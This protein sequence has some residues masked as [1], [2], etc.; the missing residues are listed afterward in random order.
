MTDE[1]WKPISG[2]EGVY[3]VSNLGRVRSCDRIVVCNDGRKYK[4]KG[5]VLRQSY[6]A[7]KY[8]KVALCKNGKQKNF[9]VH[10]LVA[11]AFIPNPENKLTVNHKNGDKLDNRV[12]NLEW[13]TREEN[14]Q[15]AYDNGLK[16]SIKGS[17]NSNSKLSDDDV[18]YIR[19]HYKRRDKTF[20]TVG[21]A[22][23]F[24][25]TPRVIG[26][27]VRGLTYKNIN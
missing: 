14:M 3:E 6:D 10:R 7:N 16:K 26:L 25:T 8:Y 2:Y 24:G 19:K 23:K 27:V 18:R 12:E 11:Q 5:K 9:S 15:H 21:L 1:I 17:S 20:G 4:R 22:T 13:A